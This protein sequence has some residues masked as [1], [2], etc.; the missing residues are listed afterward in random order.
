MMR[1]SATPALRVCD[2]CP[3]SPLSLSNN[4][5]Y[6][7]Q[8]IHPTR[9]PLPL[10]GLARPT[11]IRSSLLDLRDCELCEV[12]YTLREKLGERSIFIYGGATDLANLADPHD[13]LRRPRLWVL[14]PSFVMR[15]KSPRFFSRLRASCIGNS[16]HYTAAA[17][18]WA[19]DPDDIDLADDLDDIDNNG[20]PPDLDDDDLFLDDLDDDDL[21]LDDLDDD[22]AALDELDRAHQRRLAD[23]GGEG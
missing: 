2:V 3:V 4:A 13:R 14:P 8:K 9:V 17:P 18:A 11:R 21:F 10:L 20:L 6:P 12:S 7:I 19:H 16:G 1:N 15:V 23:G 22:L 5:P